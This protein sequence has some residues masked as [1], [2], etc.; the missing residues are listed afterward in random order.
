VG[1]YA[2]L[3]TG[4]ESLLNVSFGIT[5]QGEEWAKPTLITR[6]CLKI[7]LYSGEP[8]PTY[9][10]KCASHPHSFGVSVLRI[11]TPSE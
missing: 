5:Y 3:E 9:V 7:G 2:F 1:A 8:L 11:L 10:G 4:L 6:S